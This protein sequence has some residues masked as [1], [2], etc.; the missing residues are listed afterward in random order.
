[1]ADQ[2]GPWNRVPGQNQKNWHNMH[3]G[4]YPAAPRP[5]SSFSSLIPDVTV[6]LKLL[7]LILKYDDD[8]C[9]AEVAAAESLLLS[10]LQFLS[11]FCYFCLLLMLLRFYKS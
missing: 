6:V 11:S 7:L 3:A 9:L 8:A 1:M 4:D 10:L 2:R 5:C